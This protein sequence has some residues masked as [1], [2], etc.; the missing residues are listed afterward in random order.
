MRRL[1][2][3]LVLAVACESES[4]LVYDAP[5][6]KVVSPGSITGRVCDP[7]GRTWLADALAYVNLYDDNGLI[8]D[9]RKAFSDLDGYWTIDDLPGEESYQV[10]VTYGPY[11][12]MD[13][14]I[15]VDNGQDVVL[16][17]PNCF[18]PLALDVV[19]VTGD[20]D[21]FGRVLDD[22]GFV[23]YR[24]V[25]GTDETE[26]VDFLSSIDELNKYDLIFFNGGIIEDGVIYDLDD[27]T[28]TVP[29]TVMANI[30]AFVDAGGNIYASDWSYDIVEV[31]W[32]DKIDFVGADEVPDD[33]QKGDYEL[34]D[35]A[36]TDASL[37]EYLGK[38]YIEIEYDLPVWPPI[39]TTANSVSVHL[40]GTI[41]YSDGL[42][43]YT[44]S[45]VPL[46]ATF[47]SG[48]GKVAYSTFRVVRNGNEDMIRTLQYIMYSL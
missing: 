41:P 16:E 9:T 17:E 35:A 44:L 12:L 40:T 37:S 24:T 20:Y 13:E 18:D 10:Y 7:S 30:K 21:D 34:L 48:N 43:D 46:L 39:E 4:N 1:V 15:T 38:Q 42:S 8:Y 11:T 32:P 14:A 22:M 2:P 6:T 36:V 31:G 19:V 33:A 47:N 28:N 45:S 26:L 25:N 27:D 23:N 5:E 3:F 29:D